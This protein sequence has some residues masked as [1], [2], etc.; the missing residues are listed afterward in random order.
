MAVRGLPDV[1]KDG[2]TAVCRAQQVHSERVSNEEHV[3]RRDSI[4]V[5]ETQRNDK[6]LDAL[7]RDDFFLCVFSQ[8]ERTGESAN[9]TGDVGDRRERGK[10]AGSANDA[11]MARESQNGRRR[12]VRGEEEFR[13]R[14]NERAVTKGRYRNERDGTLD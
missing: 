3:W 5:Q 1:Q 8:R 11:K 12:V 4:G 9:D 2:G 10:S 7:N 6:H 14:E 13:E